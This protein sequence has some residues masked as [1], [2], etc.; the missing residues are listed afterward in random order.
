MGAFRRAFRVVVL[1]PIVAAIGAIQSVEAALPL[2][3]DDGPFLTTEGVPLVIAYDDLIGNDMDGDG[4]LIEVDTSFV[5]SGSSGSVSYGA[6]SL[7]YT[8]NAGFVGDDS[9]PYQVVANNQTAQAT[10]FVT[11]EAA[12]NQAPVA[13]AD[14]YLM[15]HNQTLIA[16]ANQGVLANDSDPDGDGLSVT[17]LDTSAVPGTIQV[18]GDGGFSYTPPTNFEGTVLFTYAAFDGELQS[19][20]ATATIIVQN[21]TTPPVA[22]DDAYAIPVDTVLE[23]E[24]P[25]V[26]DNDSD[27]DDQPLTA[28]LVASTDFGTLNLQADGAFT[29]TPNTGFVGTDSFVYRAHDGSLSSGDAT[30]T[31]TVSDQNIPPV[32][33]DDELAT[34]RNTPL[35]ITFAELLANDTDAD[36]DQLSVLTG[37]FSQPSNGSLAV[38]FAGTPRVIYTPNTDFIGLDTFTYLVADGIDPSDSPGTVRITVTNIVGPTPTAGPTPT[39]PAG[40]TATAS[41]TA[42]TPSDDGTG[43]KDGATATSPAGDGSGGS[44]TGSSQITTLP[45]TGTG[46]E[47]G[48]W[49]TALLLA[50]IGALAWTTYLWRRLATRRR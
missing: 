46:G 6:T 39:T 42:T 21:P 9:F 18:A 4:D 10:V 2:A 23:V 26:L 44:G 11:V 38:D 45:N 48:G 27:A 31:I 25:G 7:T 43:G 36:G 28:V 35:A 14:E 8:P 16:P 33:G 50:A 24:A 40:P 49:K 37:S 20:T 12:P 17:A 41:A 19:N 30:V 1:L 13:V 5:T 15:G 47:G 32:A 34:N 3:Q 22:N 29:Y